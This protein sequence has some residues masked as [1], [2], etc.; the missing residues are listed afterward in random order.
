[1]AAPQPVISAHN[2]RKVYLERVILDDV[3]FTINDGDR[4][5]LMGANGAGKS[6]LLAILAGRIP[7][8][9]GEVRIRRDLSMSYLDQEGGLDDS[10]TVAQVLD[11]AFARFRAWEEEL[12]KIHTLLE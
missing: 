3:S 5:G 10:A 9:A 11:G 12:H 6:T 2:L 1:M 8:E 4:V 7:P